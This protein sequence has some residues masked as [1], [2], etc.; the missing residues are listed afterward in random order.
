[1]N[2]T[3]ACLALKSRSHDVFRLPG[4]PILCASTLDGIHPRGRGDTL[5]YDTAP[6]RL[7]VRGMG[8]GGIAGMFT[9][10]RQIRGGQRRGLFL[11]VDFWVNKQFI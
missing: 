1:M 6:R 9:S 10:G 3:P 5:F 7:R 4:A 11:F 2:D 8:E